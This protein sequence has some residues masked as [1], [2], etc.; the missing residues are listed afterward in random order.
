[1][2]LNKILIFVV[3]VFSSVFCHAEFG[4]C[5]G[6]FVNP[7][8]D[9]C[10]KCM[11]PLTVGKSEIVKGNDGLKDTPNPTSPLGVC[12]KRVGLQIGYWEPFAL[13]DITDT[14]GCFSNLGAFRLPLSKA[15]KRG[16]RLESSP[17]LKQSFYHVHWYKF[18]LIHWLNILMSAGCE[19]GGDFDF[20]WLTELDPTW[21]DSELAAVLHP[22]AV[23]FANPVAQVA[24]A[25]PLLL[26]T[27]P[28]RRRRRQRRRPWP[29]GARSRPSPRHRSRAQSAARRSAPG[30][31]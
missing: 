9:V 14:P 8:T 19:E 26:P 24:C 11:F 27:A 2:Q 18:P 29:P 17:S 1:M 3:L 16:G 21:A 4:K 20:L 10:W 28:R 15:Y 25:A 23:L 31:R 22:E 7:I 6:H 5:E 30:H 13:A 12:G